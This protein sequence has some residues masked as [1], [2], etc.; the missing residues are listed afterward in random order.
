MTSPCLTAEREGRVA[1][2]HKVWRRRCRRGGVRRLLGGGRVSLHVAVSAAAA[3]PLPSCSRR[4]TWAHQCP[5]SSCRPSSETSA[6]LRA[7]SSAPCADSGAEEVAERG[8]R[9]RTEKRCE[10]AAED[11]LGVWS[12]SSETRIVLSC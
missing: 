4:A 2:R 5:A 8:V 9:C 10:S 6:V 3:R 11:F 7:D 12:R 1:R